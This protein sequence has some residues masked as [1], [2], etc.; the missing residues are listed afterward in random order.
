MSKTSKFELCHS[1][2][3]KKH[4]KNSQ[5]QVVYT[6]HDLISVKTTFFVL[7]TFGK[8]NDKKYVFVHLYHYDFE[9]LSFLDILSK[10]KYQAK[11][12]GGVRFWS[13]HFFLQILH[14]PEILILDF[15]KN[16][17][18]MPIGTVFS[19]VAHYDR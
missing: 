13:W 3:D 7:H 11:R 2:I 17:R 15:C 12:G 9:K 8:I 16:D 5:N 19:N 6:D 1:S 18:F 4:E 10:N 14:A